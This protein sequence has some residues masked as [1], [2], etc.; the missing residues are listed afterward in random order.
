MGHRIGKLTAVLT[1]VILAACTSP[2]DLPLS[3]AGPYTLTSVDN[4]ALPCCGA[5]DSTSGVKLTV[6]SGTL[7]LGH[8]T[9][10]AFVATPAGYHPE[11]CVHEVPNGAT[12]DP[13]SYPP[14]GDG[15][16][17]LSLVERLDYT[18]GSSKIDTVASSGLYAWSDHDALIEFGG[19]LGSATLQSGGA[20]LA[21]QEANVMGTYGPTYTFMPERLTSR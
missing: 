7:T 10:E 2:G 14:C 11:S 16:F 6:L 20:V 18:D 4:K 21:V 15:D 19:M 8:A 13:S 12:V 5:L 1:A 9:P 17:S 3:I